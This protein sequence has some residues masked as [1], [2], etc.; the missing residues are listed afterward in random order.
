MGHAPPRPLEVA[1]PDPLAAV[2]AAFVAD[3]RP[4]WEA[5]EDLERAV[6]GVLSGMHPRYRGR[7]LRGYDRPRPDA[8]RRVRA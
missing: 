1:R 6:D 5:L 8:L 4:A 2:V 7:L 3:D